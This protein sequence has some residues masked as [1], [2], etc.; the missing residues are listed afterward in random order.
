MPV[1]ST[2]PEYDAHIA[3]WHLMD[4]ALEGECA[5]SRNAK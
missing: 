5:I 1:Q 4:D 2:N 3:E